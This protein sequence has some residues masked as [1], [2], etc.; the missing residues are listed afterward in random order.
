MILTNYSCTNKLRRDR[1]ENKNPDPADVWTHTKRQ[2]RKGDSKFPFNTLCVFPCRQKLQCVIMHTCWLTNN[3]FCY[4]VY[5][6]YVY[7]PPSPFPPELSLCSPSP[8]NDSLTNRENFLERRQLSVYLSVFFPRHILISG[9]LIN[10]LAAS[11]C[12]L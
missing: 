3:F 8:W 4:F 2:Q 1:K 11:V 7:P 10:L 6:L 12:F 9:V 5:I